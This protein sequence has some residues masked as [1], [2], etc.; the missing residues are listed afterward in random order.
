[1]FPEAYKRVLGAE[2]VRQPL[3]GVII[4]RLSIA[5]E[6]LSTVLLVRGSTGSFAVAGL[7]MACYSIAAA[8]SLPIQGRVI[9]RIGQT[10]VIVPATAVNIA[11]FGGLIALA[12]SGGSAGAMAVMATVAG[13]GTLRRAAQCGRC[14]LSS[15]P[16]PV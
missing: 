12:H 3:A 5:A 8:I 2:G 16:I 6:P 14:G 1:M 15:F 11:G 7:V 13:L 10:R 9:D 4:G